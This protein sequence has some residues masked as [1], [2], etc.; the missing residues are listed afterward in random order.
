M[1]HRAQEEESGLVLPDTRAIPPSVYKSLGVEL[2]FSMWLVFL[3][4]KLVYTE[5]PFT[6]LAPL[7]N[8]TVSAE[9]LLRDEVKGKFPRTPDKFCVRPRRRKCWPTTSSW[10][11]E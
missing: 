9:A 7:N 6:I 5:A 8:S 4:N 3:D 1:E 11:S 10:A 2:F